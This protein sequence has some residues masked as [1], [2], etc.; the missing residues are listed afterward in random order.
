METLMVKWQA[1]SWRPRNKGAL[2]APTHPSTFLRTFHR[3]AIPLHPRHR[4]VLERS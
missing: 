4:N 1:E 3:P 2:N